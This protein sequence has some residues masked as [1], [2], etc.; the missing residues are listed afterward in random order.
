MWVVIF[1]VRTWGTFWYQNNSDL[2][3]RFW[4]FNTT[5]FSEWGNAC[6]LCYATSSTNY[7]V[8]IDVTCLAL[9]RWI[10]FFLSVSPDDYRSCRL[11]QV[12]SHKYAFVFLY[13]IVIR[14]EAWLTNW[15]TVNLL[16]KYK[17]KRKFTFFS[18]Y[19]ICFMSWVENIEI[20]I[21][22]AHSW[23]FWCFQHNRW[24]IFGIHLKKVNILYLFKKNSQCLS[25][26]RSKVYLLYISNL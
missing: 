5:H 22:A 21:L 20:F 4:I 2:L 25:R 11:I 6:N 18:K 26:Y 24:N 10:N 9:W 19:Q 23:K 3:I 14:L 1:L 15:L 7:D 13:I 17:I 16:K 12:F 8:A